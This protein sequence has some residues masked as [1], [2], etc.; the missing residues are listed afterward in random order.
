MPRLFG[1]KEDD[2]GQ[3]RE[4]FERDMQIRGFRPNTIAKYV[5]CVRS[6]VK[7]FRR[8]PDD[9]TLEDINNFQLYLT[10]ERKVAWSTYNV[11]VVA[12]RFFF[13]TTLKKDWNITSIPYQKTRRRLP[14]ILS[15]AELLAMFKSVSNVKHLAMLMIAYSAGL[16][17]S[18]LVHLKVSDID[19][20]RMMIRI[21]QGKGLKD[22]YVPLSQT[23]LPILRQ[24]WKQAR[25]TD[26]LFG[27]RDPKEP[28]N[29]V[30]ANR[31]FDK[32][33]KN[34]GITK[35][36]T[37]HSLRHSFATHLLEKNTDLR[38]I[39]QL[40]G[41][42]HLSSTMVYAHLAQNAIRNAGSPLDDLDG[43]QSIQPLSKR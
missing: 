2:M 21:E 43:A 26:W 34:T 24:Y 18:E 35:H 12:I 31:V 5:Q 39:Q 6:L 28:L 14:E 10:K 1:A 33:K 15:A 27:G 30:S 7:H 41:H 8:P 25:P 37:I 16:R 4:R 19:S 38:I 36:V 22:R 17:V 32:A 3:F 13:S 42:R 11:Y 9:L 40:L 23:L 20:E 29:R